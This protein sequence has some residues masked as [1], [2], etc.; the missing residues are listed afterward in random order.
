MAWIDRLMDKLTSRG[1]KIAGTGHGPGDF[2]PPTGSPELSE[3]LEADYG[4]DSPA[5]EPP[6]EGEG[7]ADDGD[8]SP[9]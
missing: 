9:E 3:E 8:P 7:G 2:Q 5:A 6:G 4:A 1:P